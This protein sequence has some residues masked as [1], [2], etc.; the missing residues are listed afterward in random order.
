M[1]L[2]SHIILFQGKKGQGTLKELFSLIR[3][4]ALADVSELIAFRTLLFTDLGVSEHAYAESLTNPNPRYSYRVLPLADVLLLLRLDLTALWHAVHDLGQS[5]TLHESGAMDTQLWSELAESSDK[6]EEIMHA[7]DF[8][9]VRDGKESSLAGAPAPSLSPQL[10]SRQ[11]PPAGAK[12]LPGDASPPKSV[13]LSSAVAAP[14]PASASHALLSASA[15]LPGDT[16]RASTSSGPSLSDAVSLVGPVPVSGDSA[17]SSHQSLSAT[18]SPPSS[19]S[20]A[21]SHN[22]TPASAVP[23][24]SVASPALLSSAIIPPSSG[25][26]ASDIVSLSKKH[27]ER[28]EQ[29]DGWFNCDIICAYLASIKLTAPRSC[30]LGPNCFTKLTIPAYDYKKVAREVANLQLFGP[31]SHNYDKLF[32]A[33][34]K[35]MHWVLIC[36]DFQSCE[37]LYGDGLRGA[38][39]AVVATTRRL[40]ADAWRDYKTRH[41]NLAQYRFD[42]WAT[43][44][45]K[46]VPLQTNGHDCGVIL[47]KLVECL[48]QGDVDFKTFNHTDMPATRWAMAKRLYDHTAE[49]LAAHPELHHLSGSRVL[50]AETP[51]PG[52]HS[53]ISAAPLSL[54][55]RMQ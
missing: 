31:V 15:S 44:S 29:T 19:V 46:G 25:L 48:S 2:E 55:S 7:D 40:L 13:T 18:A 1:A 39:A 11:T 26:T 21:L 34:N 16:L 54:S 4:L 5:L 53:S 43:G 41:P 17:A 35:P 50:E 33:I 9:N 23:P 24:S 45:I 28:I 38:S 8:Q 37:I 22:P 51:P 27:Y 14:P 42:K 10:A 49:L 30:I 12:S 3:H 52:T 6:F 32:V 20:P 47:C 36:V